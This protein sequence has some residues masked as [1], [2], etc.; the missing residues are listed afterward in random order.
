M[1]H[2]EAFSTAAKNVSTHIFTKTT[3][4]CKSAQLSIGIVV[5]ILFRTYMIWESKETICEL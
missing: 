4:A 3:P 5:Q 2:K 1:T